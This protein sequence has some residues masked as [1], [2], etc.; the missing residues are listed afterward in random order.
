[1]CSLLL[2]FLDQGAK[3]AGCHTLHN[4]F[5]LNKY[6]K[7]FVAIQAP[8]RFYVSLSSF[9]VFHFLL[10]ITGT[11]KITNLRG[12]KQDGKINEKVVEIVCYTTQLLVSGKLIL[13][14]YYPKI[15]KC[16][17]VVFNGA[18]LPVG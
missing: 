13:V 8:T 16:L 3:L 2:L 15:T 11:T 4:S 5:I 14:C 7:L 17:I 9:S 10:H 12:N 1:M 6:Y 18:N